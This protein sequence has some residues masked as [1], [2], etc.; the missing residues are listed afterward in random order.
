VSRNAWFACG[1]V[2]L[3]AGRTAAQNESAPAPPAPAPAQTGSETSVP[4]LKHLTDAE[5][6]LAGISETPLPSAARKNLAQLRKDFDTMAK[7]YKAAPAD[8]ATW[9]NSLY[10][11]ERDL[12]VLIGGGGLETVAEE[13][14]IPGLPAEVSDPPARKALEA[15]RT[16]LELFYDAATAFHVL[17]PAGS[18][19]AP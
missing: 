14:A 10:D 1:L 4:P 18:N 2:L 11:V 16:Q 15:Y 17:V 5:N 12:T 8:V 9:Q 7:R 6:T 19:P 3:L 13:K